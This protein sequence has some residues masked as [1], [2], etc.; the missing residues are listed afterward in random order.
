MAAKSGNPMHDLNN[1]PPRSSG[2]NAG[3]VLNDFNAPPR[4]AAELNDV[5]LNTSEIVNVV[6]GLIFPDLQVT[7]GKHESQPWDLLVWCHC[8][9]ARIRDLLKPV[10]TITHFTLWP[11]L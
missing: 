8:T 9:A 3:L 11:V 5:T 2:G 10:H 6:E 1:P 4:S 7:S